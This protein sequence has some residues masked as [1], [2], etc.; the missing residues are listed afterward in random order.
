MT[1]S[2]KRV[3]AASL[4]MAAF[5]FS[6]AVADEWPAWRGPQGNN[7]AAP[8]TRVP[9]QWDLN[10]GQHIRWRA[11]IPGRGHSTPLVIKDGIFLTTADTKQQTQSLVKVDPRNGQLLGNWVIHRGTLPSTIHPHNSH[12][13]PTPAFDGE[14]LFV[15]F[16]TDDAIVLT[17]TTTEGQRRWQKRV[18]DFRPSSFQFGYGA[19]PLVEDRLVIVAAEYDGPESGIYAFDTATG[20]LV[21]KIPR[22]V[23]LNFASPI[24]ATL[25]GRRQLLI[26]GAEMVTSYDPLTGRLLWKVDASTEA[27]CSTVVWDGRR[28]I[29]SGGNPDSGTWCVN[30]DG[31]ERLIW[32]NPHKCY[33]Q[34]L[35]A[36]DN[37]VF[38]VTD[39]GVV[40]CSRTSDGAEM[41]KERLFGGGISASP[42]LVDNRIYIASEDAVVYVIDA[43]PT[44]FELFAKIPCGDSLFASP[45]AVNDRIY[46]R[47]GIGSGDDRQEYLLAIGFR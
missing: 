35:L 46:L 20:K 17:S 40:V 44:R 2:A 10:T 9:I 37:F 3:T 11:K 26:A 32:K 45:I 43:S 5:C 23:N 38:A 42:L 27:I 33:E 14:N 16:H 29:T 22:P 25:A 36:I 13:S 15:V 12:A 24:A 41:W 21:W 34:S 6:A 28:V 31:S 4:L 7:H 18:S 39:N 30:G 19:S 8:G 47:T 1:V